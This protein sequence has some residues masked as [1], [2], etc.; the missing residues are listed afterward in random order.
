MTKSDLYVKIIFYFQVNTYKDGVFY[1]SIQQI[2]LKE[3]VKAQSL[4][5]KPSICY[6]TIYYSTVASV[7]L[8]YSIGLVHKNYAFAVYGN[9]I[10]GIEKVGLSS[11]L[12][13]SFNN[14]MIPSYM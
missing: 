10:T 1:T 4:D 7:H 9:L 2:H 5:L 12:I 11:I 14:Y 13:C 3:K 6:S 8:V